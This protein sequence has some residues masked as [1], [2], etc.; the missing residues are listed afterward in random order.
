MKVKEES[1]KGE[2]LT[3][4]GTKAKSSRP[5]R[6]DA[7]EH[8]Q[9][10]LST[11]R[12]LF[13]QQSVDS[14]SMHQ[15]ALEAGVGQGTLYRHFAHKGLLCLALLAENTEQAQNEFKEYL[16][17]STDSPLTQ[18]ESLLSHLLKFNEEN[19]ELL[20]AMLDAA[21][22]QRRIAA[23][24]NP[25]YG[26]LSRTVA[27]LLAG[28][29]EK[30]EIKPLDIEYSVDAL[31]APLGIDLYL[32]QRFELQFSPERISKGVYRLL[33]EGLHSLKVSD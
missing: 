27:N 12:R 11:A 10:I 1:R 22:G 7:I 29:V 16:Q 24:D 30:G 14:I 32:Y 9:Q 17:T 31:L 18:L 19:T 26:W 20:A 28:A 21:T 3:Q 2:K 15:I 23:Y 8:R 5:E 13:A 6:R 25:F 33:F 4:S